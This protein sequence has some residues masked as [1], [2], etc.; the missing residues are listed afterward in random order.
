MH[1]P[2]INF[3]SSLLGKLFHF[4]VPFGGICVVKNRNIINGLGKKISNDL[5]SSQMD[6]F[7]FK[8]FELGKTLSSTTLMF[9]NISRFS[10][11]K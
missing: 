10:S 5:K 2:V 7:C 6:M 11:S 3:R 9:L 1:T 8:I 4:D